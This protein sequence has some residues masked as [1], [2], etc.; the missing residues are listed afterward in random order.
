MGK[1]A[2][3]SIEVWGQTKLQYR[4]TAMCKQQPTAQTPISHLR[5]CLSV[6]IQ[7]ILKLLQCR[8]CNFVFSQI[9]FDSTSI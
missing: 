7:N 2:R 6:Y 4:S 9:L 5:V 1:S 3:K 8:E